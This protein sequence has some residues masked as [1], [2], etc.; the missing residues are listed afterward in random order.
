[1]K[2]GFKNPQY[3][4]KNCLG[5]TAKPPSLSPKTI[6]KPGSLLCDIDCAL[7]TDLELTKKK[8]ATAPVGTKSPLWEEI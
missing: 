1:V 8:K 7:L 5:C 6:R 4:D 2:E 3:N